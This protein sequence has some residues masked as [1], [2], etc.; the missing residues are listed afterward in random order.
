MRQMSWSI[1]LR[2]STSFPK[3]VT[4]C[5]VK[6]MLRAIKVLRLSLKAGSFHLPRAEQQLSVLTPDQS[7]KVESNFLTS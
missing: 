7:S 5:L 1:S 3:S 6:L 2:V 4:I